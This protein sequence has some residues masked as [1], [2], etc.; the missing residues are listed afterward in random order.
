MKMP[1][2]FKIWFFEKGGFLFAIFVAAACIYRG[3]RFYKLGLV[4]G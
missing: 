3:D 4:W 2:G 1:L